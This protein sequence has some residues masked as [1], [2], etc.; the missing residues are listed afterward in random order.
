MSSNLGNSIIKNIT[1]NVIKISSKQFMKNQPSCLLL[2]NQ[3]CA[4]KK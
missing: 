2:K 1:G 4:I 3:E